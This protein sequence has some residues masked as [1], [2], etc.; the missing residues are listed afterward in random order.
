MHENFKSPAHERARKIMRRYLFGFFVVLVFGVGVVLG[1]SSD[2]PVLTAVLKKARLASDISCSP[3]KN[4]DATPAVSQSVDFNEFWSVWDTIEKKS[5]K[6]PVDEIQ[7]YHGALAGLVGSLGDPYSVYFPPDI[8]EQFQEEL[9]GS[10]SGIGAEV[11]AKDGRIVIVSALA[12]TPADRAGLKTAD[13]ISEIDSKSTAGLTVD[14]AVK[15][16]RGPEGTTV[17][18]TIDRTQGQKAPF[19]VTIKRERIALQS[20]THTDLPDGVMLITI[21][22]FDE[23]TDKLFQDAVAAAQEK[24][25]RGIILDLRNNPGGFFDTSISV[26]S[27]WLQDAQTVVAE[28]GAGETSRH[29]Y[30][31]VG[32]HRLYGIPT[33]VLVNGGTASAA[34]IVSGALQDHQAATIIGTKSFGKGSVQEYE[35]LPDGSGLKLTVALWYTPNDRSINELGITPDIAL[36]DAQDTQTSS[37]DAFSKKDWTSDAAIQ[38]ALL[39]LRNKK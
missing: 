21:K 28:R 36:S 13:I 22:S 20:V 1:H 27:E 30:T 32:S 12:G 18:L 29:D 26:A 38:R 19:Q 35:Q 16:I 8:A 7:L 25:S 24:K 23:Q 39:F 5:V 9:Q 3:I 34:E 17:V 33:V 14:E 2:A 37:G 10:F 6:R 11:G 31:T 15:R 4:R